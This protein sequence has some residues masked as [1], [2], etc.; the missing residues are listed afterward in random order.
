MWSLGVML[1]N[2]ITA[3]TLWV[4]PMMR[5]PVYASM[6]RDPNFWR[7]RAPLSLEAAALL[8][9]IITPEEG[10][11]SLDNLR[12]AVG[13]METLYMSWRDFVS[14]DRRVQELGRKHGPWTHLSPKEYAALVGRKE[15]YHGTGAGVS[16]PEP[17]RAGAGGWHGEDDSAVPRDVLGRR[18]YGRIG[19]APEDF[20]YA[21]CYGMSIY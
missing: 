8:N 3:D 7:R 9:T 10:R 1:Y 2:L 21:E 16:H 15:G 12:Q 19:D 17:D 11:T 5:D 14:A 20:P 6:T 13:Q 4:R 18:I